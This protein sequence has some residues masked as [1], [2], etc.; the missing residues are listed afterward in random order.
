MRE[1]ITMNE[2]MNTL[3]SVNDAINTFVW[4]KFGLV[5]LI[6]TGVL[7]TVLLGFFQITHIGHWMKKTIGGVFEKGSHN[8]KEQGSSLA[9]NGLV[10]FWQ[11]CFPSLPFWHPSV[12]E[13]W[14]RSTRSC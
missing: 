13:T 2:F 8:K 4:V 1:K 5:M 12:L 7:M 10:R 14:D 9:A 3:T 11:F 6:G